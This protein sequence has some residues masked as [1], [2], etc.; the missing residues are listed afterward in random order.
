MGFNIHILSVRNRSTN[1]PGHAA[2]AASFNPPRFSQTRSR[3]NVNRLRTLSI[4]VLTKIIA[5]YADRRSDPTPD[6]TKSAEEA[7]HHRSVSL[8]PAL[9]DRH[10]Q[11]ASGVMSGFSARTASRNAWRAFDGDDPAV[12]PASAS[13]TAMP[14]FHPP[15]ALRNAERYCRPA[16]RAGRRAGK[17]D[18][19]SHANNSAR[20]ALSY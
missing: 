4:S 14:I 10:Q 11:S 16:L 7:A 12:A 18:T 2:L 6:N 19:C 9:A 15:Y 13:A 17:L 5:S 1:L 3:S 20:R 8:H